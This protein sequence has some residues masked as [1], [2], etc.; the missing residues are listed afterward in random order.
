M[1]TVLSHGRVPAATPKSYLQFCRE[2]LNPNLIASYS[3]NS[4]LWKVAAIATLVAFTVLLIGA[5]IATVL[6][7]PVFIPIV[8]LSCLI[9]IGQIKKIY[10][11]FDQWSYEASERANQLSAIKGHYQSLNA[12]T[13]AHIQQILRQKGI[14]SV[15]GMQVN[16]PNLMTL[17]PLIARHLFWEGRVTQLTQQKQEK[18]GLAI[19]LSN[20]NFLENRDEIYELQSE[21]LEL[22]RQALESRAK[23]V[24]INAVIRRPHF[25]GTSEDLVTLS[26][27]SGQERAIAMRTGAPNAYEF[28][29]FKTPRA[30]TTIRYDEMQQ[31]AAADLAMRMVTAMTH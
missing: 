14:N 15:S 13:P 25:I 1:A 5:F 24:F 18:I 7:S 21:A 9:L 11:L 16:D 8:G 10:S 19:K 28:L 17:K 6:Y 2:E 31:H 3:R 27:L 12:S 30:V 4:T 23:H 22:E 26:S 20:E 29:S